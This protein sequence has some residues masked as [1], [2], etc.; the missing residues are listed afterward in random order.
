MTRGPIDFRA[1]ARGLGLAL[2]IA[3]AATFLS[4]HYAAPAM[5][6]ALLIGMA[7]NFL[8]AGERWTPGLE[9]ASRTLLRI[10]VALLGLRL[11]LSDVAKIGPGPSLVVAALAALVMLFGLAL[12]SVL[13]RGWRFG[14]LTGGAVAICGASA[15]MA[16]AAVLPRD[17]R[18]ERDVLFTVVAV[19]SLSTLAM[20]G[21]P[22]LFAAIGAS[23]AETGFLIGA[24]IH[25]VAQVVGAGYS[26]SEAAGD[27]AI[28]VKLQRVALLPLVLIVVMLAT[29][30]GGR[31]RIPGFVLGFAALVVANSLGLVPERVAG[32]GAT[33]SA[34]MLVTAIAALGVKTS[35]R[36][37]AALGPRHLGVVVAETLALLGLAL[38]VLMLWRPLG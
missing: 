33:A 23:E 15:A 24:T 14:V 26:V 1:P 29:R 21:Y 25:D 17:A 9:V 10:G 5:L 32:F 2:A 6:F 22:L 20:I 8:A 18:L 12:A 30:R 7:F 13:G 4:A 37:M 28:Y 27:M 19:T 34:W 11:T 31:A 3:A 16:L 36:E 35:L 38:A